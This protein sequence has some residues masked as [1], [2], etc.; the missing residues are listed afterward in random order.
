MRYGGG[1]GMGL[2]RLIMLAFLTSVG[3]DIYIALENLVSH[4]ILDIYKYLIV[5]NVLLFDHL[6]YRLS[7][8][9]LPREWIP[10]NLIFISSMSTSLKLASNLQDDGLYSTLNLRPEA[11]LKQEFKNKLS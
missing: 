2:P 7:G 10:T 3:G 9:M 6:S 5:R 11:N 1:Q 4:Q 8:A